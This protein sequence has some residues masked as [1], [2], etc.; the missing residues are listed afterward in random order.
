[1]YK[2]LPSLISSDLL[3]RLLSQLGPIGL[4]CSSIFYTGQRSGFQF[5]SYIFY[6]LILPAGG[7][8]SC[9]FRSKHIFFKPFLS[10]WISF[11]SGTY[12]DIYAIP[13]PSWLLS[14]RQH[15][16]LNKNYSCLRY[17]ATGRARRTSIFLHCWGRA[18]ERLGH[19][20]RI[21]GCRINF[22]KPAISSSLGP[23]STA[24]ERSQAWGSGEHE[25]PSWLE[26]SCSE[27]APNKR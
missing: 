19:K 23:S 7:C 27:L 8:Y 16:S 25:A 5:L 24:W 26:L 9:H 22:T 15:I 2:T 10:C 6:A 4:R 12:V 1:M 3:F 20:R 21:A 14:P 18:V 13:L 11:T 17:R